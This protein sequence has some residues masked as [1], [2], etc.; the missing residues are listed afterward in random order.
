MFHLRDSP[1]PWRSRRTL[2][3]PGRNR[4]GKHPKRADNETWKSRLDG[5]FGPHQAYHLQMF[6]KTFSETHT[7]FLIRLSARCHSF[8]IILQSDMMTVYI[9]REYQTLTFKYEAIFWNYDGTF[10]SKYKPLTPSKT[11]E[12]KKKGTCRI[13]KSKLNRISSSVVIHICMLVLLWKVKG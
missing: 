7:F 5:R 12:K 9:N 4:S 8:V 3:S 2:G 1:L 10:I 13:T 11:S 6:S